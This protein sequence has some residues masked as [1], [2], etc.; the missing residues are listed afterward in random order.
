VIETHAVHSK[1]PDQSNQVKVLTDLVA[2]HFDQERISFELS[3]PHA[4]TVQA[5]EEFW[6]AENHI[7]VLV[8]LQHHAFEFFRV[9][10][11]LL[12]KKLLVEV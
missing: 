8:S 6:D 9:R 12:V 3:V 7:S 2:R 11:G 5:A 1:P 10:V 4:V